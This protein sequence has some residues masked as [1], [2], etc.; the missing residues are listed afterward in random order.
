[1]LVILTI[2]KDENDHYHHHYCNY[3][4]YLSTSASYERVEEC[5]YRNLD[6]CNFRPQV[7]YT[8]QEATRTKIT[9]HCM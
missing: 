6:P 2:F 9:R 7:I 4:Q 3:C 5:G 8:I 1:M